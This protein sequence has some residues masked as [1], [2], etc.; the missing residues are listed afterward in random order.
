M[1]TDAEKKKFKEFD[2]RLRIWQILSFLFCCLLIFYLF[3][4]QIVDVKHYRNKAKRQRS[5]KSFV[6]RGSILDRNGLKLASDQTSYNVYAHK[7]Y[8]DHTPAE[9][10]EILSPYLNT[11][12]STLTRLISKPQSIILLKKDIDRVTAEKI[13]GLELREV[14]LDKKNERVYPQGDM[15]AH[16]LGF[17][18]PDADTASGIELIAKDKLEQVEK[19]INF[20][21]TPSGD[22]IYDVMTDPATT[23]S[24]LMGEAIT[25]TIDSA[26]QHTCETELIKAIKKKEAL[27]GSVIVMNP[28]NGEILAYAV[29]PNYNPNKYKQA[30]ATQLKNWSLTDVYPPGSTFKVLTIASALENGRINLN[31]KIYDTGK[32]KIGG[33]EIQNY[34]YKK[35][36]FPG[37]INLYSLLEHSSNVGSVRI[38][39]SMT[40]YE[41]YSVLSKFGIGSKTEIDL[42][43]E[44]S[45]LLPSYKSWDKSRQA[46]MGYGYGASVTAIQMASAVS[47]IA[48]H[49]VKVTPHVIKYSAEEAEKK[50]QKVQVMTPENAHV[51]TGLLAQSIAQSKS[52]V[53]MDNYTVAA[54]T[55]TS[56]K[57]KE[58]G[59]GYTNK[60]I[61]S[62]IGY[63]PASDPQVLIYVVIDSPSGYEIWGSTVAAPVFKEVAMQTARIM[64]ITPDKKPE[65]K[66]KKG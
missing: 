21:K 19:E 5:A 6:M 61:T 58:N 66:I 7:E 47:A 3:L 23:T 17:F 37:W 63:F 31:S 33:W 52:P 26:I 41:F 29:Y 16:I 14:S 18:N 48:N 10:A 36:P 49:G 12:V 64:N 40:P 2:K 59:I 24:P 11:N 53:K 44:S 50:I 62:V 65:P 25:L 27:R 42:P 60:L 8:F 22:I 57:T 9:L 1:I 54:K 46:T 39:L 13:Q 20:E 56:R 28:K 43:G 30:T 4:V 45:G 32:I 15:A 55:G 34:D 38:A 35:R 51:L